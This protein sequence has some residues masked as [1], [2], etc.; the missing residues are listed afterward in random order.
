MRVSKSYQNTTIF[1]LVYVIHCMRVC[2]STNSTKKED[3]ASD[4]TIYEFIRW[5]NRSNVHSRK[6]Y[7][8]MSSGYCIINPNWGQIK[9]SLSCPN[10]ISFYFINRFDT[11]TVL[12][13]E[14]RKDHPAFVDKAGSAKYLSDS[15]KVLL[16]L[17]RISSFSDV[18]YLVFQKW[19]CKEHL[20]YAINTGLEKVSE[21]VHSCILHQ[22]VPKENIWQDVCV[23]K[24]VPSSPDELRL[25]WI[26]RK[27]NKLVSHMLSIESPLLHMLL[28]VFAGG[29]LP[30]SSVCEPNLHSSV[31]TQGPPMLL[32]RG[33]HRFITSIC[34]NTSS[35]LNNSKLFKRI[36]KNRTGE[37]HERA[38]YPMVWLSEVKTKMKTPNTAACLLKAEFIRQDVITVLV[39][40]SS[41]SQMY[42]F[43]Y[44][45]SGCPWDPD[46]KFMPAT[47]PFEYDKIETELQK[48]FCF[49][50]GPPDEDNTIIIKGRKPLK[51]RGTASPE[52][53]DPLIVM[54]N[55]PSL[56]DIICVQLDTQYKEDSVLTRYDVFSSDF[57]EILTS[58]FDAHKV[59]NL[60]ELQ[61]RARDQM[62][63]TLAM[64]RL[65]RADLVEYQTIQTWGG[66]PARS[67]L[68]AME[69]R[70]IKTQ[71]KN[72]PAGLSEQDMVLY[73]SMVSSLGIAKTIAIKRAK[74]KD[75]LQNKD[76]EVCGFRNL[77]QAWPDL[78]APQNASGENDAVSKKDS[79][80]SKQ[81][82]TRHKSKKKNKKKK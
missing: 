2:T 23:I 64:D 69:E 49:A 32:H 48:D 14:F 63:N 5:L 82:S 78:Y 20:T 67:I 51:A 17:N 66:A 52:V 40:E 50:V 6:V 4:A 29:F 31:Y 13:L 36:L 1:L 30:E 53:N 24:S 18:L 25:E 62:I 27:E 9:E 61:N 68:D 54:W 34:K 19:V 71:I 79:A 15:E 43:E 42:M 59:K 80:D 38:F 7:P 70:Y 45:A 77:Q 76:G 47:I 12:G 55:D 22:G 21:T 16:L 11:G 10:T 39:I 56:H 81:P 28:H 3:L 73:K 60:L 37:P 75:T 8:T 33:M 44:S 41:L 58:L 35:C 65:T 46:G 74:F 72:A 26:D 57:M